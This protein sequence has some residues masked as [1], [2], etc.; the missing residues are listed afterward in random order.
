MILVTGGTGLVGS[1]LVFDLV[2]A[3]NKVRVL[4]RNASNMEI[5][6][7]IFSGNENLLPFIE[8][9]EGDVTDIFSLEDAMQD[10]KQVYHCAG[11]VSFLAAD[12]QRLMKVNVEGTSNIVNLALE[13]GVEKFCHVS[14]TASLGRSEENVIIT[15]KTFWKTSA[16]NSGYSI[17][18]Y[19]AEREV[20]RAIEEGLNA[21]IV[22]PSIVIGPG[23]LHSGSTALFGEIRK[24]LKFYPTGSSGF[25]DVR[26]VSKCMIM[27][28][29]G[30]VH[31]ERFI[32]N[33][34][35]S[36]YREVMNLIADSFGKPRPA[37]RVGHLLREIGWRAE[38]IRKVFSKS[39]PMITRETA[40][41]GQCSWLYSNE[42]IKKT[43]GFEF[44]SMKDSIERTSN[45][46]LKEMK[47][48]H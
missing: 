45:I 9:A 18:K 44:I 1:Q 46:F 19:G 36:S 42:K 48:T 34:E 27:L 23:N 4:K 35:N 5:L 32:I 11:L 39:K 14:S 2:K 21:F 33:A 30:Q 37:I 26:D 40:R 22:N 17:S 12:F 31:S 25:V 29:Q 7:R 3:G 41:N 43:L 47:K 13:N 10:V 28:M 15:E 20:W 16:Y 38:M 6:H 24:G 8:W